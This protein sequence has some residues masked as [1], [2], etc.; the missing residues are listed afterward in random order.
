MVGATPLM[1]IE[2]FWVALGA[3]PL[4]ATTLRPLKV[5]MVVGVP[6][7]VATPSKVIP[8]GKVPVTAKVGAGL[9]VAVKVWV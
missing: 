9:P 4:L 8:V 1:V 7:M 2:K 3:V 6:L 5:A